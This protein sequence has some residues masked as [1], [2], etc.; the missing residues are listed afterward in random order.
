[1]FEDVTEMEREIETFRKNLAASSELIEGISHLTAE[2]KKQK[3][4][5]SSSTAELLRK[6]DACVEQFKADH[7]SALRAMSDSNITTVK[8][9]Q[10]NMSAE[11]QVRIAELEKI[12]A[13]FRKNMADAA[14]QS[15]ALV[16]AISD[17]N[18]SIANTF[19]QDAEKLQRLSLEQIKQL[20]ADCERI[21]SDMKSSLETQQN[22]FA[23]TLQEAEEIIKGYQSSAEIKYSEFV[24]RLESTNV[25]QIFKEVQDLKQSVRT[26][27]MILIGGIGITA[28]VSIITLILK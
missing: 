3:E 28:I 13:S 23:T 26:K 19:H 27:F 7:D 8:T 15:D 17:T 25:D 22:S 6:L 16:K 10:E 18:E 14:V 1:M 5:F 4:S 24:S 11:Q 2:T 21:I 20:N 12:E 9:L